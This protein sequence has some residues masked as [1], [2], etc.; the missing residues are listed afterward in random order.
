MLQVEKQEKNHPSLSFTDFSRI[1]IVTGKRRVASPP[2]T[3]EVA[4]LFLGERRVRHGR[5]HNSQGDTQA[6]PG[7]FRSQV[8]GITSWLHGSGDISWRDHV[9]NSLK[10][11][12]SIRIIKK[13]LQGMERCSSSAPGHAGGSLGIAFYCPL[14]P[15]GP[16]DRPSGRR[17]AV[18][19][20]HRGLSR[21]TP[22]EPA[23]PGM[24]P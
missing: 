12:N 11:L 6:H 23:R 2:R 17:R 20:P 4:Q 22:I 15:A 8:V 3:T 10:N 16:L 18:S 7:G 21:H 14:T 19:S 1:R 5:L 13:G 24:I 9:G